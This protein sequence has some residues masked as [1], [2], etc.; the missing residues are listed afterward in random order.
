MCVVFW[1]KTSSEVVSVDVSVMC[2]KFDVQVEDNFMFCWLVVLVGECVSLGGA[3]LA[4]AK[5]IFEFDAGRV[6]TEE[7]LLVRFLGLAKKPPFKLS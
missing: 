2:G 1:V 3:I 5:S 7:F 6:S 4:D